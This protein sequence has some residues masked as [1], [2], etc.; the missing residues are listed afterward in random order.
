LTAAELHRRLTL[1]DVYHVLGIRM[2]TFTVG[3]AR[4]LDRLELAEIGDG[5]QAL[6]FALLCRFNTAAK[7]DKWLCSRFLGWSLVLWT[8]RKRRL[9]A[10]PIEVT[11][12]VEA[13]RDYLEASTQVPAHYSKHKGGDGETIGSPFSQH[14]RAILISK[15]GYSPQSVDDTP[16]LQAMWDY[17]SYMEAE[18]H[19]SISEGVTDDELKRMEAQGAE[20]LERAK[21]GEFSC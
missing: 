3:H 18:G 13:I 6:L 8:N 17:L 2:A 14:L 10:N 7:A 16:F 20:L 11:A 19:I 12:A 21:K 15:L 5:S 4:L 1:P 9:L